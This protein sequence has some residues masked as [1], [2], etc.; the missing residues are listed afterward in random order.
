VT[1]ET[2][3]CES[4]THLTQVALGTIVVGMSVTGENNI[5]WFSSHKWWHTTFNI[6]VYKFIL[7]FRQLACWKH[8][9]IFVLKELQI[10]GIN[11]SLI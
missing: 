1:L 10:C 4:L 9:K 7:T 5:Q 8:F 11:V 6:T 3:E 2:T